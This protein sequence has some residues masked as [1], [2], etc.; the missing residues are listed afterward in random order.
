MRYLFSVLAAAAGVY[1]FLIFIRIILS[2]FAGSVGGKPVDLL[3]RF[4]DPYLDWWRRALN[5]RI[6]F[7]DLSPIAAIAGLSVIQNVLYNLS[8]FGRI[9]MG[10]ILS[11]VLL[12]LWSA[13]SFILGFCLIILILRMIAY[14]TNRDIYSPFWRV[15]DSISQPMLYRIN[16]IIFGRRIT[17]YLKGIIVSSL[18]LAVIWIGGR[19]AVQMLATMLTKLP[20]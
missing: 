15:I 18:A 6:G 8:V 2:W 12:A 17:G 19:F 10:T 3:I 16:R 7:L 1:S 9:T 4:T 11:V 13:A 14:L 5:L 20:L